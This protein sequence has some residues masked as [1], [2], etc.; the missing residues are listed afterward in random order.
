MSSRVFLVQEPLRMQGGI[1]VPRINYNTLKPYGEVHFLFQWGEVKDDDAMEN[2]AP[3]I[4]KL[5]AKLHDFTNDDYIVPLGN[6]ALI[7][8]AIAIA[9]ECND[10][11]V[12]ILDWLR[13][14][15]CYRT[16]DVDLHCQP[17]S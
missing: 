17:Q 1:A 6:P 14:S 13:D 10:G 15:S 16:V 11:Q 2:T 5:R 4:W 8:M 9:A 3:L 12:R 7:G